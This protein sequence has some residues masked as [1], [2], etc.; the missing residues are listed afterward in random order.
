MVWCAAAPKSAYYCSISRLCCAVL[1]CA[2]LRCDMSH[3]FHITALALAGLTLALRVPTAAGSDACG[4]IG[5]QADS[6]RCE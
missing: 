6:D 5:D 3:H 2:A 4:A 1:H